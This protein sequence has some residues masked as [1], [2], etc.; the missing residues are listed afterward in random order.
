MKITNKN[1]NKLPCFEAR[2]KYN[3]NDY[4]VELTKQ[5]ILECPKDWMVWALGNSTLETMVELVRL[6]ADVNA[7]YKYELWTSIH[8]AVWNGYIET[9]KELIRL[10]A[11][12]NV[13]DKDGCT[14]LHIA[15]RSGHTL[16]VTELVR[17]GADVNARNDRGQTPLYVASLY[18]KTETVVELIRLGA[19]E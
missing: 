8:I 4:G 1:F 15:A 2:E 3:L 6:G 10:G 12:I 17:I 19:L 5:L 11:D 13:L 16:I 18:N 9:A 7:R 14:P